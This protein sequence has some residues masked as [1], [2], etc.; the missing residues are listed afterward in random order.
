MVQR[1]LVEKLPVA[2]GE[3]RIATGNRFELLERVA[4][5]R[6]FYGEERD[7]EGEGHDDTTDED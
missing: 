7:E 1:V 3:R 6:R 4:I 5:K 2:A